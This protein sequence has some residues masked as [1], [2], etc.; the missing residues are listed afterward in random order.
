[1]YRKVISILID[2]DLSQQAWTRNALVNR[3]SWQI[4]DRHPVSIGQGI[5]WANVPAYE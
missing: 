1:M 3:A 5:L 2:H 4:C